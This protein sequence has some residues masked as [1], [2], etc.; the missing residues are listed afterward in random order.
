L[1]LL[2]LGDD[3]V[4]DVLPDPWPWP[5]RPAAVITAILSGVDPRALPAEAT[6][7]VHLRV[8]SHGADLTIVE[9][10]AQPIAPLSPDRLPSR[11]PARAVDGIAGS[12]ST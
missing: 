10:R 5:R 9:Q 4:L 2:L 3:T 7:P 6:G 12:H 11:P 1:E 8:G